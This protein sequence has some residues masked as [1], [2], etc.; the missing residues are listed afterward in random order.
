M[1]RDIRFLLMP[2]LALSLALPACERAVSSFTASTAPG[3]TNRILIL[4]TATSAQ[5]SGLLDVLV[6]LFEQQTG[7][8]VKTI[9]VGTGAALRMAREGNADVLLVHAPSA[10]EELMKQGWGRDRFPVM[11]NDFVVVGPAADPAGIRGMP[12]AVEAFRRIAA[13]GAFFVSRGDDSGTHQ[14]ERQVWAMASIAPERENWYLESGQGM[15]ATLAIASEKNAYTLT[16]RST[17]IVSRRNL[18]LEILVEGDPLLVNIYHVIT[19]NPEKWPGVNYEGALA[20]AQFLIHPTTQ[21]LIGQFGAD[22][23]GQPLFRAA[24]DR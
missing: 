6:P 17:Y 20:F 22:R 24:G 23:F 8:R 14:T 21:Q 19:V 3:P 2:V 4:A 16:D 18:R 10:E 13:A 11:C 1:A 7:Y 12:T 9:A 5:D 15:G